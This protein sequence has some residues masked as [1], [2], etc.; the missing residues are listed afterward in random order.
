MSYRPYPPYALLLRHVTFRNGL[1][2]EQ[3][4]ELLFLALPKPFA[5]HTLSQGLGAPWPNRSH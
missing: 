3:H 2:L 4:E 5:L 1:V